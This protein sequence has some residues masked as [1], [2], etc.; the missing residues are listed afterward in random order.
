M[1]TS[2][3]DLRLERVAAHVK[4]KD[5]AAAMGLHRATVARYEGLA[6]VPDGIA[7]EYRKTLA[8]F[9]EVAVSA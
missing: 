6:V 7:W 3:M 5:L 4:L 2:G 8:T 1:H 9:R